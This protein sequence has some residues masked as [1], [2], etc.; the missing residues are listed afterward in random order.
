MLFA[1]P[2]HSPHILFSGGGTLGPV[3]PL[4]AVAAA[5]RASRPEAQ[6]SWVGTHGGPEKRLVA[7]A[8]IPFY[9][10]SS[11]RFRR[12]ASLRNVADAFRVLAGFGQ[13]LALLRRLRPDV[14]VS[15]GGF[16]AVPVCWAARILGIR[17][18]IHQQDVIPGLANK[19]SLGAA[20][21]VSVALEKSLADFASKHPVWT[22]NP[23][24]PAVFEGSRERAVAAFGLDP[25]RRTLLVLGGG[26]GAAGVNALVHGAL[27]R[28]SAY[29]VVHVT[30]AGK[31]DAAV[32]APHYAQRELLTA[33]MPDALAVADLVVTRA[34]MG[35][36]T[37]LA[38][39]GKP[40]VII[41][42]PGSH[43]E[44]N[45][46]AYGASGA[47]VLDQRELTPE[48]LAD[49]VAALLADDGRRTAIGAGM[50][51]LHKPDAATA[52]ADILLAGTR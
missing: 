4:L 18:Y 51:R 12:Y 24:R 16:V 45:A 6:L 23:I 46:A 35:S 42:M 13:S 29:N 3:T 1:M 7:E 26:T 47:P 28:L 33:D 30:G 31:A 44:A 17:V 9:A 11:G 27:P 48:T 25:A 19:L 39:L 14:V 21:S 8:N 41:P 22:G 52:I 49:A 15:A 50:T 36:L 5:V 20:T 10:V 37:E 32:T 2:S 40:C 38:A 34:G 43:Q